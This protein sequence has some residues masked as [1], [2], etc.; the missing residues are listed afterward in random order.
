VPRLLSD[1]LLLSL[2]TKCFISM[3]FLE[4]MI[5]H[6]PEIALDPL[7]ILYIH[8]VSESLRRTCK[9]FRT[10]PTAQRRSQSSVSPGAWQ[11]VINEDLLHW[12]T[13]AVFGLKNKQ[14]L[15]TRA[16]PWTLSKANMRGEYENILYMH[17]ACI[18]NI[19]AVSILSSHLSTSI[20]SY[21]KIE[22]E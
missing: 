12:E 14:T 22:A 8:T 1:T 17:V 4:E 18:L 6:F 15:H 13:L 2:R 7:L 10:V 5:I 19:L 16:L 3:P 20:Y 9:W 11:H 21:A